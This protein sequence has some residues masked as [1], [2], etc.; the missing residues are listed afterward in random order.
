MAGKFLLL[1]EAA[2][3]LG[4]SAD[5]VHRL[6][7]KKKLF[8]LRD[9]T[10]LKFKIDDL[11]RLAVEG[12]IDTL[13]LDLDDVQSGSGGGS[14]DLAD[15]V[16]LP[17]RQAQPEG[18]AQPDSLILG[19]S[20]SLAGDLDENLGLGDAIGQGESIF[21]ND[22]SGQDDLARTMLGTGEAVG[23]LDAME[24][25]LDSI[26]GLSSP[27]VAA[28]SAAAK[29]GQPAASAESGPPGSGT[30]NVELSGID[31]G[32]QPS[33][34]AGSNATGSLVL[35]SGVLGSGAL[36]SGALVS[37][38]EAAGISGSLINAGAALSGALDS[39]LSL[40]D[41]DA[42]VSGI[43]L[44]SLDESQMA[45]D[46]A[47]ALAGDEFE[48]G[49]LTGDDES[50]SVVAVEPESGDSSFFAT[51]GEESSEFTGDIP[52]GVEAAT[53]MG[54]LTHGEVVPDTKFSV[55]QICSLVC[56]ALL[57]LTGGFV[58]FDLMRTI[59]SPDDLSLSSP[60]LNPL[61][62]AFGWR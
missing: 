41:D 39:G 40:E 32:S 26:V 29:S 33:N 60:L 31:L 6:V 50:A 52:L 46:G 47:T 51:A 12:V 56:C 61:A 25:D 2:L 58:M 22:Q 45:E 38:V 5:E 44:G 16:A 17:A 42:A 57:L 1:E 21:A 23:G 13:E 30:F 48:L 20:G 54:D 27:S 14:I 43:D 10:T 9:G 18:S 8:P 55:W 3:H 35:G 7:E 62:S 28:P 34:A 59:G 53:D 37:G 4:V 36:N 15:S 49:G 24:L 19:G 11:D